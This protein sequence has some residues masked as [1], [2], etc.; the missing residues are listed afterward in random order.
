MG[1]YFPHI[2]SIA[3]VAFSS[4][5]AIKLKFSESEN[6]IK[7][8]VKKLFSN[9]V[10]VSLLLWYSY[11]LYILKTNSE[12]ITR[13]EV[14]QI[15]YSITVIFFIVLSFS[16]LRLMDILVRWLE[17]QSD[18]NKQHLEITKSIT[19]IQASANKALKQDK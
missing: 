7:N 15:A 8:G 5:L 18:F 12:E 4:W 19:D 16:T 11:D 3:L 13:N 2:L 9:L 1:E 6:E 14:F 17:H 10:Y